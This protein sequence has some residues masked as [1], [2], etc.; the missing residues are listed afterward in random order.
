MTVAST[1][2]PSASSSTIA[3]SSIQGTGVQNLLNAERNGCTAVSG[4]ALGPNF[5]SRMAASSLVRPL[6]DPSAALEESAL[7]APAESD[8][9]AFCQSPISLPG[10]PWR[11]SNISY[12]RVRISS[13]LGFDS[14][15][16]APLALDA[17]GAESFES[18]TV[19]AS[20]P[21]LFSVAI[22]QLTPNS[23]HTANTVAT[24]SRSKRR[25]EARTN[26]CHLCGFESWQAF[27]CGP[28]AE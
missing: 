20:S 17:L 16:L 27:S 15:D 7:V 28:Y 26:I 3:A 19:F 13:A 22:L 10:P 5:L 25:S 9:S 1:Y 12:A 11:A 21:E 23:F 14:L 4:V 2:L 8:S 18:S 24:N 6:T